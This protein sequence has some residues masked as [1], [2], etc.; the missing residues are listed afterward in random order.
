MTL[1]VNANGPV[2]T[3]PNEI[4]RWIWLSI[5]LLGLVGLIIMFCICVKSHQRRRAEHARRH[6]GQYQAAAQHAPQPS[7]TTTTQY[8]YMQ[9]PQ[10]P[11]QYQ[12]Q[13]QYQP[14]N[15]PGE[16]ASSTEQEMLR[17]AIE[18][19][20]VTKAIEDS[21]RPQ[22][23]PPQ[24][25]QSSLTVNNNSVNPT[26]DGGSEIGQDKEMKEGKNYEVL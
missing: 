11:P 24:Q 10:Q 26:E 15:Q 6:H 12:Y 19:S 9:A 23:L 8:V 3:Y 14:R 18:D 17:K 4:G 21:Q 7:T 5:C 20:N 2:Q 13:Q 22:Y 25:P 16:V 1:G